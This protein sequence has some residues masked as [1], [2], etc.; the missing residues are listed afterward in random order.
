MLAS[1]AFSLTHV[2]GLQALQPTLWA[3]S[4]YYYCYYYILTSGL[5]G[6]ILRPTDTWV[7]QLLIIKSNV[8]NI[9]NSGIICMLR[10]AV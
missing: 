8:H 4:Y 9:I 6:N 3:A 1:T 7:I 10:L 5:L 2:C